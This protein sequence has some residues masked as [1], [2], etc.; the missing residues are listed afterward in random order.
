MNYIGIDIG[1]T[2]L[3]AGLVNDEGSILAMEKAQNCRGLRPESTGGGT[4]GADSEPDGAGRPDA[5]AD[6]LRGRG[7]AGSG[8]DPL[9]CGAVHL[10]SAPAE[11]PPPQALPPVSAPTPCMWRTTP[12][13]R[14][15]RNTTPEPA[16]AASALSPLRWGP[17]WEQASSTT[18]RSITALTAWPAR[19]AT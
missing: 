10:Q 19:W 3:K 11:R 13:V 6:T 9:R 7:R 14:R 5:G 16:R 1:G 15:W 4:G 17:A 12:T 18:D 8:G 2:N